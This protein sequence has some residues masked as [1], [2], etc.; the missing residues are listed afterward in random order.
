MKTKS[1]FALLF[2]LVL[3]P[4]FSAYGQKNGFTGEWK[5]DK[6]KT[7]L[8]DNQ[9]FL[10]A[11]TINLKSDSLLATRTY[12]NSNGEQYPFD[13][14][15]SL[16]GKESKIFIYDMPRTIK[17]SKAA[18]GSLTVETTTTFQGNN[19][20]DNLVAKETWKVDAAGSVLTIAFV[21]K[22]AGNEIPGTNYYNKVK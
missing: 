10:A 18:D 4:S 13:E 1:I 6:V 3:I 8:A 7:V 16:D 21:N 20:P 14:K 15:I 2:L 5:I 22:M 17:A 11:I 9:L 19:G 12:E